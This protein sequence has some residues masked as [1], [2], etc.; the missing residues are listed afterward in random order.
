MNNLELNNFLKIIEKLFTFEF[1]LVP[2]F[3]T[4]KF[5]QF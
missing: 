4:E 5:Y 1:K 3:L 2:T